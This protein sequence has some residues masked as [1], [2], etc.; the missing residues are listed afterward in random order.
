MHPR[1]LTIHE[2]AEVRGVT[3]DTIYWLAATGRI[4]TQTRNGTHYYLRDEVL[5]PKQTLKQEQD[6]GKRSKHLVLVGE[7]WI[8]RRCRND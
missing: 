6:T 5:I 2:A 1:W 4:T 8:Y 7:R 3:T